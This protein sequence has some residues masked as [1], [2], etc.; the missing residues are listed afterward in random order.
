MSWLSIFNIV[1][2]KY[3]QVIR[4]TF[5]TIISA[6]FAFLKNTH[7]RNIECINGVFETCYQNKRGYT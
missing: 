7:L 3:I 6:A 4:V 5:G 2:T 1:L